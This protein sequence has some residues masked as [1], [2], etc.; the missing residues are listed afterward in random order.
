M[1][2]NGSETL[3]LLNS[4][5]GVTLISDGSPLT[6][7][8]YFDGKFLR[9]ED[10]QAEQ[11]YLRRLVQMSNQ[12]HGAGVVHGFEVTRAS[13]DKLRLAPGLAIDNEGRVLFLGETA[14]VSLAALLA[15]AA[16]AA[17][18]AGDAAFGACAPLA[19]EPGTAPVADAAIYVIGISQAEALC[20][21]EDVYGQ[22]CQQACVTESARPFRVEGVALQARPLVLASPLPTSTA[23]VL[24]AIHLRSRVASAYFADER[25]RPA[26]LI[27]QAG[28]ASSIWCAGAAASAGG[29]VPLGVLARSGQAVRFLDLWTARRERGET[30][31]LRYWR[32]RLAMRPWDVFLAQVLQFQCQLRDSW[33]EVGEAPDPCA[34]ER[35]LIA[36]ASDVMGELETYYKASSEMLVQK[37]LGGETL[38]KPSGGASRLNALLGRLRKAKETFTLTPTSRVLISKGIVELPSGGYLPVTP[39][40]NLTVNEQ[41]RRLMGEGVDLRFCVVR[42]DYVAHALESVQHMD[43]ISLL[44]GLDDPSA[45][46]A[47]DILVPD[48][49]IGQDA[50]SNGAA[51]EGRVR[52]V[53]STG[54]TNSTDDGDQA[55]IRPGLSSYKA[56]A[57]SGMITS[58]KLEGA[59]QREVLGGAA[60]SEAKPGGELS[61][62][63]AGLT[64][65]PDQGE[66]TDRLR[67]WAKATK[68]P[69]EATLWRSIH[70]VA[71]P[72]AEAAG[73]KTEKVSKK[74]AEAAPA[75]A[76]PEDAMAIGAGYAR[77][78]DEAI[79]Y[80]AEV[81]ARMAKKAGVRGQRQFG[82]LS[83]EPVDHA[84]LWVGARLDRDPFAAPEQ[85]RIGGSLDLTYLAPRKG[86]SR[87]V[88][89]AL[90]GRFI[91]E[92]SRVSGSRQIVQGAFIGDAVVRLAFSDVS[93]AS[94]V[95][96][97][98]LP[99]VLTRRADSQ[100]V[101][102]SL[103]ADLGGVGSDDR[104]LLGVLDLDGEVNVSADGREV[105]LLLS[106]RGEAGEKEGS[107]DPLKLA[108][109]L[110]RNDA[111]ILPGNALRAASETAI[112]VLGTG[113]GGASFVADA[114]DDL[115]GRPQVSG[116]PLVVRATRDWVMFHRR[117]DRRCG[118]DGPGTETGVRRYQLYHLRVKTDAQARTAG[119]A[120]IG[121]NAEAVTKLGFRPIAAIEFGI[122]RSSLA[123]PEADVLA[124]WQAAD[125]G[126]KLVFGAIG[127]LGPAQ[128]EG[129]G[130][131]RARLSSL[132]LTVSRDS[133][134]PMADNHVLP[135]LPA[136][137][138]NGMDGALFLVTQAQKAMCHTIYVTHDD[139]FPNLVLH[140][141]LAAEIEKEKMTPLFEVV[142]ENGATPTAT[143]LKKLRDYWAENDYVDPP[144][145]SSYQAGPNDA[146]RRNLLLAQ[147][148]A[149]MEALDGDPASTKLS[150]S[151]DVT[152]LT[153]CDAVTVVYANRANQRIA[154]VA[155]LPNATTGALSIELKDFFFDGSALT[156]EGGFVT[157]VQGVLQRS[158]QKAAP[159][160][161]STDRLAK[162]TTLALPIGNR[163]TSI[164]SGLVVLPPAD[165]IH[166]D[167][168]DLIQNA[169]FDTDGYDLLVIFR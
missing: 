56:G 169:G 29:F 157:S 155:A 116:E 134:P 42:P 98:N 105:E 167:M 25:G 27:S 93:E 133:L 45:K 57:K 17:A 11:T 67:E 154:L 126:E 165:V 78:K 65:L 152:E 120:V 70:D 4:T 7:L 77:L 30:H 160:A 130:L 85:A 92:G 43:R 164:S 95:I 84:A 104:G 54:D 136:L 83:D 22:A 46:E 142:F 97:V 26:S 89:L 111:A 18:S 1:D 24:D 32:N 76:A 5:A 81:G 59:Y 28:L 51:W 87:L 66:A 115:F 47:V 96:K 125:P 110:R 117:R 33:S 49:Q 101:R 53:P 99:I 137:G 147:S 143:T 41:V 132:E 13:G 48:G 123:T 88:D 80:R 75:P 107:R 149:I 141:G 39:A 153:E 150:I 38:D 82:G 114:Q 31:P 138:L 148:Q 128:A 62:F 52:R 86:G 151:P 144:F 106:V 163:I 139:N 8:N 73:V 103:N 131:A 44:K 35:A 140:N 113:E 68:Q 112:E 168:R 61:F 20:G 71:E 145:A 127:S 19:A 124:D 90:T 94:R 40:S 100:G 119:A 21:H 34:D 10:L 122:G 23:V 135:L 69:A 15:Q 79:R 55:D 14:E 156:D 9:A 102:V 37:A 121:A 12:A 166:T 60:R 158:H 129:E 161:P 162:A 109:A 50:A 58:G 36:E 91:V 146:A 6:R 74:E 3:V 2:G 63:F 72:K 64:E 118:Q 108:A 159:F 16:Q